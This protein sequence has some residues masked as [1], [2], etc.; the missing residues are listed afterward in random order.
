MF[1]FFPSFDPRPSFSSLS[2][3]FPHS[4][5]QPTATSKTT[6]FRS[7]PI[8]PRRST[9]LPPDAS[10]LL[11]ANQ[12]L[13]HDLDDKGEKEEEVAV[14]DFLPISNHQTEETI[15]LAGTLLTGLLTQFEDR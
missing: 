5:S 2:R 1:L 15:K 3:K 12:A 7:K 8:R 10:V 14:N 13:I 9:S 4:S 6:N 11:R